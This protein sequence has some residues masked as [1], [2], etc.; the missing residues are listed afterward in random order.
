[1][2]T[3]G[4]RHFL[5]LIDIPRKQ[6]FRFFHQR[7][8]ESSFLVVGTHGQ[9]VDP[10]AMSFIA[11]HHGGDDIFL[12]RADEKQIGSDFCFPTN[13]LPGIV[14]RMHEPA[15]HPKIEDGGFVFTSEWAHCEH[16]F[17]CCMI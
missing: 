13:V 5:D 8:A 17:V 4:I 1:M 6:S 15:A 2:S 7:S 16:G 14:R 10:A 3:D 11:D 9:I 12:E